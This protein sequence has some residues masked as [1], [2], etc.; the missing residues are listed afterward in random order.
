MDE[1][2]LKEA[3]PRERV[4]EVGGARIGMLHIPG[5]AAGRQA[6]LRLRFDGCDA[7]VYGHTHVPQVERFE[8]MWILN[9]G[10]PTEKRRAPAHTMLLLEI[11]AGEIRPDLVLLS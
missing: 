11:E 3:L 10:S 9:P 5:P 7:V 2:A 6:R 1:P 8:G 4:V